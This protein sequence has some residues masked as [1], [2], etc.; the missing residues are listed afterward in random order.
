MRLS[1]QASLLNV[2]NPDRS[3]EFYQNVF[4]LRPVARGDRVAALMINEMARQQVLVLREVGGPDAIHP[5]RG[6]IGPRLPALEA[7]SPHELDAIEQRL[8]QRQAF[9]GRRQTKTWQAIVGVD[10]DRIE[11]T[12]GSRPGRYCHPKPRLGH[13][14][15]DGPRS[16]RMIMTDALSQQPP[17]PPTPAIVADVMRPPLTTAD[18]HDH[19]AAA[20]Y[21]MKHAGASALMVLDAHTA[22][23][24]GIITERDIARAVADGKGLDEIR[25]H[26]LMTARPTVINPATSIRDAAKLMTRGNFRHLPVRRNRPGRHGRYHR[27]LPRADRPRRLPAACHRQRR[28]A[29]IPRDTARGQIS[30]QNRKMCVPTPA[31][32]GQASGA[33]SRRSA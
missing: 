14:R 18:Q 6:S 13:S 17:Q 20:A 10:P 30:V 26:D 4:E 33:P 2:R 23:P 9:A 12:R 21:L 15:P 29:V 25:I 3:L 7:G 16:R 22:Q 32:L 27:R 24:I 1:L 11:V 5:G 31:R 8:I 28:V 19:A